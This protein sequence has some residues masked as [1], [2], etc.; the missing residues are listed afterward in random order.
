MISVNVK[1][2]GL[3]VQ[4]HPNVDRFGQV[5]SVEGLPDGSSISD[6]VR[7]LRNGNPGIELDSCIVVLNNELINGDRRLRDGDVVAFFAPIAGG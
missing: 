6:L 3:F 4:N 7:R 2:T 5:A 1:I